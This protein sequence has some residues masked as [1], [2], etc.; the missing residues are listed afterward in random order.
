MEPGVFFN[1]WKMQKLTLIPEDLSTYQTLLA[2]LMS[3]MV[4]AETS[5]P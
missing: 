1:N 3:P 4:A 2:F 5:E